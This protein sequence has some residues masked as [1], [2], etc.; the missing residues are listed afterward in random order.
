[1]VGYTGRVEFGFPA[2]GQRCYAITYAI[3]SATMRPESGLSQLPFI[4]SYHRYHAHHIG[5]I[6]GHCFLSDLSYL[7]LIDN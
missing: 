4:R 1:M 6:T 7:V 2:R 3:C 5:Y